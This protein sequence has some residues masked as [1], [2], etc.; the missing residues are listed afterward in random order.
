MARPHQRGIVLIPPPQ[1]RGEAIRELALTA[2][3][4]SSHRAITACQATEVLPS[5]ARGGQDAV[6]GA[7]QPVERLRARE[8]LFWGARQSEVLALAPAPSPSPPHTPVPPPTPS[9]AGK[10]P[11]Q[12][13]PGADPKP[14]WSHQVP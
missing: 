4:N 8:E 13:N 7:Q 6:P 10:A 1:G 5:W 2:P 3:F 11:V 14:G 9:R 12:S